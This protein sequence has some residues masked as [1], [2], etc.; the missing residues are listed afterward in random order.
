MIFK[1]LT[2]NIAL[3]E[4]RSLFFKKINNKI[5]FNHDEMVVAMGIIIN[6]I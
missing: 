5:A 6:P 2:R 1:N 4:K 3:K